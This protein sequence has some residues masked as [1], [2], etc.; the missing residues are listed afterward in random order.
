[1][2]KIESVDVI[3][4]GNDRHVFTNN[5]ATMKEC[6]IRRTTTGRHPNN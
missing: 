6:S 3:V 5:G 4:N 2:V 1:M